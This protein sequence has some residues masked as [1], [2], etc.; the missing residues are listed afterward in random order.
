M[1]CAAIQ[2][3]GESTVVWGT[4]ST[5]SAAFDTVL[6]TP[7]DTCAALKLVLIML[8]ACFHA[9]CHLCS[10]GHRRIQTQALPRCWPAWCRCCCCLL[11]CCCPAAFAAQLKDMRFQAD[12]KDM[13]G[14]SNH[15]WWS[16]QQPYTARLPWVSAA[17]LTCK[18]FEC[19][20]WDVVKR[21]CPC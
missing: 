1:F 12:C 13:A 9:G 17:R 14:I 19:Q 15:R 21:V 8:P 2:L 18:S 5:S 6:P 10:P 20:T 4:S 7:S 3:S 11:G 16:L